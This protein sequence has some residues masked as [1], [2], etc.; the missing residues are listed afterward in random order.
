VADTDLDGPSVLRIR[1]RMD[2]LHFG[3]PDPDPH[4]SEMPDP[5]LHRSSNSEAIKAQNEA[6]K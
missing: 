3:K 6:M 1:I 4:Q 5:D 2:S